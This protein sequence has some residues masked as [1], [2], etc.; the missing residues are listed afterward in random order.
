MNRIFLKLSSFL[1]D[2][3]GANAIEYA[4]LV[5]IIAIGIVGWA[6][7]IGGSTNASFEKLSQQGW[8]V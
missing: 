8:G 4:L 2:R 3:R 1:Y 7:L 6:T 5:G